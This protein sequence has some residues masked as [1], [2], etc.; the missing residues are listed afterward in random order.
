MATSVSDVKT[1]RL[2]FLNTSKIYSA[3]LV[4]SHLVHAQPLLYSHGWLFFGKLQSVCYGG[5]P[6][7]TGW[8]ELLHNRCG[9]REIKRIGFVTYSAPSQLFVLHLYFILLLSKIWFDRPLTVPMNMSERR[10]HHCQYYKGV[11]KMYGEGEIEDVFSV[12][13][14][15]ESSA[16]L[17]L[18]GGGALL[19]LSRPFENNWK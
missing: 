15:I 12:W 7:L 5:M 2:A 10:S 13:F 14:L 18:G 11:K 3:S 8:N 1:L 6:G 4:W 16:Y 17:L 19:L 9:L